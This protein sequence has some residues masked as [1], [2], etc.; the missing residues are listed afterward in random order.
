MRELAE[1]EA[2]ILREQLVERGP[3]PVTFHDGRSLESVVAFH[4]SMALYEP[5]MDANLTAAFHEAKRTWRLAHGTPAR[6]MRTA[7]VPWRG[8]I[9]AT[10]TSVRAY[11]RTWICS[12]APS[13]RPRCPRARGNCTAF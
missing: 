8:G 11:E 1:R 6:L 9:G 7:I 13:R 2:D 5:D 3:D 12:T 10:L 4:R